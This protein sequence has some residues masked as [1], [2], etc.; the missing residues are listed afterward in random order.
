MLFVIAVCSLGIAQQSFKDHKWPKKDVKQRAVQDSL[1]GEDAII[2]YHYRD[3]RHEIVDMAN[4]RTRTLESIRY[5]MKIQTEKGLEEHSRVYLSKDRNQSIIVLDARTIKPDGTVI[6]LNSESIKELE[7]IESADLDVSRKEIRF[8]VPGLEVGDEVEVIYTLESNN[9]VYG[10]N[11]VFHGFLPT[12]VSTVSITHP[13][14]LATEIRIYNGVGQPKVSDELIQTVY[15]WKL[16]NLKPLRGQHHAMV[17]REVPYLSY[18]V[19]ALVI[20][21]GGGR[22][23]TYPL[24]SNNWQE[25]FEAYDKTY[26]DLGFMGRQHGSFFGEWV[27]RRKEEVG[28]DDPV[29]IFE[30]CFDWVRDRLEVVSMNE[31][32]SNNPVGY[33][34][35]TKKIDNHNLHVLYRKLFAKLKLKYY[36]CFSRNKYNGPVDLEFVSPHFITDVFYAYSSGEGKVNFVYPSYESRTYYLNEYPYYLAGTKTVGLSSKSFSNLNLEVQQIKMPNGSPQ[37]SYRSKKVQLKVDLAGNTAEEESRESYSGFLSTRMRA[38][39]QYVDESEDLEKYSEVEGRDVESAKLEDATKEY[40]F[41]Y[42]M[43]THAKGF[44]GLAMEVEA[45]LYALKT[46]A[47]LDHVTLYSEEEQQ[48]FF[49]YFTPYPYRDV[50]DYFLTFE[51]PVELAN[52]DDLQVNVENEFGEYRLTV[53]SIN[54]TMVQVHS[55]YIVKSNYLPAANYGELKDLNQSLEDALVKSLFVKVL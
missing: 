9:L 16:R 13:K 24:S 45:G 11:V 22:T 4:F 21:R 55:E 52:K 14:E 27:K 46:D 5:R 12:I 2:F 48:R 38:W 34:L 30:H 28:T 31:A 37:S 15:R 19:R 1:K 35:Y 41:R 33:F 43:H 42:T 44:D 10:D 25:L 26:S 39:H 32:E 8:A 51:Q 50:I 53:K 40:P 6:D 7:Y 47:L 23:Q 17:T 3:I 18:A 36:I 54:P 29:A 20:D 49:D